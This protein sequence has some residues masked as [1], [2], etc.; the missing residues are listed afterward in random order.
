[1]TLSIESCPQCTFQIVWHPGVSEDEVCPHC[2]RPLSEDWKQ[3][4][5]AKLQEQ[6]TPASFVK[7][8]DQLEVM[9]NPNIRLA[10]E[11]ARLALDISAEL[12]IEELEK[13]AQ[14][15][16]ANVL[17]CL[18]QMAEGGR[19]LRK[20]NAWAI[21]HNNTHVL[22]R[23]HRHLSAF[24]HRIGDSSSALEFALNAIEHTPRNIPPQIR[25]DH[26]MVLAIALDSTGSYDNARRRFHEVLDISMA[27]G[28]V[29]LAMYA[30]NN[31]AYT[32]YEL[33]DA[34]E[35]ASLVARLRV[36]AAKHGVP[37][38]ALHLDTIARVE[39]LLGKPEDA[40]RT[41]QPV[42]DDSAEQLVGDLTSLPEC[43]LTIA[44]AQ[45]L[46]GAYDRAQETIDKAR[47]LCE[48]HGFDGFRVKV[49]VE[50]AQLYAATGR[51]REAYEEHLGF[52]SD[53]EAL[54]STEREVR[55]RILQAV[56]ETEEARRNSEYFREMALRDP[57]TGLYNRRFID[58][59]ID[60]LIGNSVTM[61][62]PLT[63][64][65]IDL[66]HFKLINDT[67]SH[68]TGDAVLIHFAQILTASAV[69]PAKS[70]R[71]GG[72]EFLVILP[73]FTSVQG[74]QFAEELCRLIRFADWEQ[75]APGL[76]VTASIGIATTKAHLFTRSALLGLAD[77]NLYT[78]KNLGRD[79]AVAS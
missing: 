3:N 67:F 11:P 31:M 54:R 53:S 63:V 32:S 58:A 1:M 6:A 55:V 29:P 60:G 26:L 52:H 22:A 10:V 79:R 66:D 49:R 74:L 16:H 35:A 34:K 13:R 62:E 65:L 61:N 51:Y 20:I 76:S 43:M 39:L 38:V 33:G 27:T 24:F 77:K 69:D 25:A 21:E 4:M 42:I 46:Q 14:L 15:V 5:R 44:E 7:L 2:S 64:L 18:G 71:L 23:S 30:L 17:V 9:Y 70:A 8:L 45:R 36:L 59:H 75:I 19:I 40:E 57:L 41:L 12:A 48:T 72:E 47:Q 78:A 68:E 56:F 73:G 28:H 50:Q 37:L